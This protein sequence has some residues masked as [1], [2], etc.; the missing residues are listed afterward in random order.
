[1]ARGATMWEQGWLWPLA[2]GL[3][4]QSPS[5]SR[6]CGTPVMRTQPSQGKTLSTR[7]EFVGF[8]QACPHLQS[9][10]VPKPLQVPGA[11]SVFPVSPCRISG[12]MSLHC[13]ASCLGLEVLR[14]SC[15]RGKRSSQLVCFPTRKE[16]ETQQDFGGQ[17]RDPGA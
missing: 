16:R 13:A 17:V 1:M 8:P 2:W 4:P 11:G 9:P 7:A 14:T 5:L 3:W 10:A 12:E 15:S 6:Q